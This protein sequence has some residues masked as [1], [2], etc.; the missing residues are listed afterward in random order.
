MVNDHQLAIAR[1]YQELSYSLVAYDAKEVPDKIDELKSFV[2]R[3]RKT[4]VAEVVNRITEFL[5]GLRRL[6][7]E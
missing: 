5:E 2:P 6:R 7:N 1:K 4:R 3:E